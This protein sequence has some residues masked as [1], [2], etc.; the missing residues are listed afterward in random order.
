MREMV[1]SGNC[2]KQEKADKF[3]QVKSEIYEMVKARLATKPKVK[4][5]CRL[6][7]LGLNLFRILHFIF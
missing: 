5:Q 4:L 2:A 7:C 6:G 1:E 3:R